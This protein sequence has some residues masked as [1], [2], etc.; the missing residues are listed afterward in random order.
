MAEGTGGQFSSDELV[1]EQS[2]I[3]VFREGK[4]LGSGTLTITETYAVLM[5]HSFQNII[6]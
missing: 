4:E 3:K 2:D 5:F 6:F 1:L